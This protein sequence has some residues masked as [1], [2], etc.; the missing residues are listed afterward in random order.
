MSIH[1]ESEKNTQTSSRM[2]DVIEGYNAGAEAE[3]LLSHSVTAS[4]KA[5]IRAMDDQPL[6]DLYELVMCEVEMPLLTC[7]L[8]HTRKNQSLTAEILG[9]NRGTLR[10]KMKKYGML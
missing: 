9:L 7:V 4:V 5:Y 2:S 6:S 8:R 1:E 3:P 10:K